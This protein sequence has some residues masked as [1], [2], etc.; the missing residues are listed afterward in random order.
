MSKNISRRQYYVHTRIGGWNDHNRIVAER[1]E[2]GG[3]DE[4]LVLF[5][6]EEVV[7]S[8]QAGTYSFTYTPIEPTGEL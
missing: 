7:A 1:H 8:F 5:A 2:G 6:D 4:D 3:T